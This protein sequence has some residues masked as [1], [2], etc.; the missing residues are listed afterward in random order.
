[1][2]DGTY[3]RIVNVQTR[4]HIFTYARTAMINGSSEIY[5]SANFFIDTI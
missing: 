3:L 5:A 2:L 4:K 1:M